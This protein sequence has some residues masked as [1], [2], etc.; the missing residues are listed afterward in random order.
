MSPK[1][2]AYLIKIGLSVIVRY[3]N[4]IVEHRRSK[5]MKKRS[6]LP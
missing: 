1:W 5:N 2:E 4:R 3:I 6:K